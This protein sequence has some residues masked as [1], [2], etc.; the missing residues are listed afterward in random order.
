MEKQQSE[1]IRGRQIILALFCHSPRPHHL[2]SYIDGPYNIILINYLI[3]AFYSYAFTTT[4]PPQLCNVIC[5]RPLKKQRAK[6]A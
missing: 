5:E 2:T 3:K 4:H 6:M 1:K